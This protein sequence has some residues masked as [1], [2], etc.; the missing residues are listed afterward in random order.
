M[1]EFFDKEGNFYERGIEEE[2]NALC[3]K[4]DNKEYNSKEELEALFLSIN[5]GSVPP[6][7]KSSLKM[8]KE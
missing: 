7:L 2:V 4:F 3:N 8:K 6:S 1:G 5:N